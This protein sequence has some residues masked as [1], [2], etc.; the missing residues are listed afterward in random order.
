MLKYKHHASSLAPNRAQFYGY[1]NSQKIFQF[2]CTQVLQPE[3]VER[4]GQTEY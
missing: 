3:R 4:G 1:V 2:R